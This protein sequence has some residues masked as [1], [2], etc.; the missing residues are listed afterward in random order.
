MHSGP[1]ADNE[2]CEFNLTLLRFHMQN[3]QKDG[4]ILFLCLIV[5]ILTD[6]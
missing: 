5:L 4:M 6:L 1:Y 2:I 3:I